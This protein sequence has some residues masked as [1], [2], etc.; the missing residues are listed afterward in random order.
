MDDAT[1]RK[2]IEKYYDK[3]ELNGGWMFD[4]AE[5]IKTNF[6]YYYGK[7]TTGQYDPQGYRKFFYQQIKPACD[8]ASKFID[9]DTKD[10]LFVPTGDSDE[11]QVWMIEK[12]YRQ[13][14]KDKHFGQLMNRNT[15][16]YPLG[17]I[18]NKK[19]GGKWHSMDI[20]NIR[21]NPG[22]EWL[23]ESDFV[24]EPH[25]KSE[26]ELR[27]E[28]WDDAAIDELVAR[29][30]SDDYLV[31]ECYDKIG[32][33]KW[34]RT[35]KGDLY[36]TQTK[37]G[38]MNRSKAEL[39]NHKAKFVPTIIL[40][41]DEV[42]KLPYREE[43]WEEVPGRWLGY[44]FPEYLEDN[45]IAENER[46]NLERKGLAYKSLQIWQTRDDTVGGSNI[47]TDAQNGDILKIDSELQP[48]TKDN[49]DLS[50]FNNTRA[51][52]KDNTERK[53]FTSDITTGANLPSRTPL[54]V[55]NLQA[56]LATSYFEQK[57]EKLGLYYKFMALEDIIPDFQR[58]NFKEHI[59][60]L[61]EPDDIERF[62]KMTAKAMV[63]QAVYE[64]ATNTGF[65]PSQFARD[66]AEQRI[67]R[68]LQTGRV[69]STKVSE[70]YYKNAKYI[71]D[72]VVTGESIDTGSKQQMAQLG[73]QTIGGNPGI[74]ANPATRKLLFYLMNQGG[75]N[76]ASVGIDEE[77][78]AQAAQLQNA[79]S[80][81]GA[82]PTGVQRTDAPAVV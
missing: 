69:R 67:L 10:H 1:Q 57:R 51:N 49:S 20:A 26:H 80:V 5:Q 71:L 79:G 47:L 62:D 56:S 70:G 23:V 2:N 77:D 40:L 63:E 22:A 38:S 74:V 4:T 33:N 72:V 45:Q 52:W 35:I 31:Y 64:H 34:T 46:E 16:L 68:Q 55:A 82:A 12:R 50:A 36:T 9:L 15:D 19:S 32:K 65:Y 61:Y 27:A 25:L 13:Y 7:Y 43:K 6:L 37:N 81:A 59:L 48:L 11:V 29:G 60:T 14:L 39:L 8:V 30:P 66:E 44:G 54:G 75:L 18:V 76:L 24:Y 42:T 17:H 58:D 78:F 73:I 3:V 28:K 41:E 53:T 21:T